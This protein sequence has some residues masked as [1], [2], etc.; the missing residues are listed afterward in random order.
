MA[1]ILGGLITYL[2]LVI[3]CREHYQE[4][5]TIKRVRELR[6]KIQNEARNLENDLPTPPSQQTGL[7]N[8]KEQMPFIRNSL[9][10]QR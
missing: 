1:Q 7:H 9:N 8:L 2:L 10:E 5:V 6:I 3:Y 4:K